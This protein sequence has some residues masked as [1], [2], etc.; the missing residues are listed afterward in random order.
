MQAETRAEKRR[1]QV[2]MAKLDDASATRSFSGNSRMSA[3][4]S[5]ADLAYVTA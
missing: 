2:F 1:H 4:R 3:L 5:E